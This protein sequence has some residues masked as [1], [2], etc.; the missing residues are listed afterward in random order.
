MIA[1][2]T[3]KLTTIVHGTSFNNEQSPYR[4]FSYK[5]TMKQF[6]REKLRP[7]LCTKNERQT[8]M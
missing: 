1:N 6:K 8:N 7:Y 4:I 2:E 3:Q 5:M